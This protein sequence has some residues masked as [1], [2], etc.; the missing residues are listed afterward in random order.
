MT[1]R[2]EAIYLSH[3]REGTPRHTV[4]I[5]CPMCMRAETLSWVGWHA[6]GCMGCGTA[7]HRP[8]QPTEK[9]IEIATSPPKRKDAKKSRKVRSK[10]TRVYRLRAIHEAEG[11]H[12]ERFGT[13]WEAME[14]FQWWERNK[15]YREV[16]LHLFEFRTP[17]PGRGPVGFCQL[18]AGDS[19]AELDG[20]CAP[21]YRIANEEDKS[22]NRR[23]TEEG[24]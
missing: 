20:F 15:E 2:A 7:L 6:W 17:L 4:R 21:L 18:I 16:E 10:A 9:E 3:R 19:D 1:D 11:E 5:Q 13:Q 22:E 24:T 23:D 14:S 12:T 8:Y